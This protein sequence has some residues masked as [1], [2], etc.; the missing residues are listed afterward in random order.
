MPSACVLSMA[1]RYTKANETAAAYMNDA[2]SG[3]YSLNRN[4]TAHTIESQVGAEVGFDLWDEQTV[5]RLIVEA[6]D[7]MPYY[8]SERAVKRGI[9]LAWGKQQ[10]TRQ[11][12]S[13]IIQGESIKQLADRLQTNIP[14]MNRDSAIRAA[15]TAVTGAQ[16]AGRQD[17]Y[18]A[19]VKMGIEMEKQWLATLDMRTRHDHAMADG[20]VVAEDKPF[21]VGGEALMFPGDTSGSGWNI[22]NCRCTMIAK[23]KGVDMSDAKR[24]AVDSVTGESEVISNMSY[25]EWLAM[26]EKQH[27]KTAMETARKQGEREFSDRKQFEEYKAVLGKNAPKSFAKFQD[28]KYNNPENWEYTKRLA[29][30]MRKYPNSSRKYFD[31]QETLKE[32]GID[33]GIA[34]PPQQKHAYILSSG[35][36]DPYHIMHRMK[37]RGI[38]DDEV[39]SYVTDAKVMFVQWGGQRQMFVSED[40]I[41]VITKESDDWIY[42][43][44]WKKSDN[45]EETDRIMEAIKNAGL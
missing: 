5:K 6:P 41:S 34:L 16:N 43:T 32:Q 18:D 27:G 24:R 33:K 36:H 4:Y 42:K 30:Y 10:I 38:T 13:G 35:K 3:I 2:T 22:Y 39:R 19:A 21:E 44:A 15:R 11:V 1:E 29:G 40:G 20:Q 45:D 12:T 8:P 28:L 7:L 14:E 17:S 25:K 23:V 26:K 37:E 9:D 31:V